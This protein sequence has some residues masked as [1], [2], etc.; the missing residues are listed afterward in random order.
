MSAQ[1]AGSH[2]LYQHRK[3]EAKPLLPA[4]SYQCLLLSKSDVAAGKRITELTVILSGR[5]SNEFTAKK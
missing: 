5:T 1:R 3:Q 2:I 4:M